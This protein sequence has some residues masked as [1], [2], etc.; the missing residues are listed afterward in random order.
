MIADP[1]FDPALDE[2]LRYVGLD[3]GEADHQIRPRLRM[4]SILAL[5]NAE[6]RA[7]RGAPV[8]DAR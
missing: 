8:R 2:R 1:H 5:V 4:R 7:F 3:I 6:T